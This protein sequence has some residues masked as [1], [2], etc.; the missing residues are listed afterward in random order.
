MMML[1][2]HVVYS[3][4]RKIQGNASPSSTTEIDSTQKSCK[5]RP[6]F[7]GRGAGELLKWFVKQ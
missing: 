4:E 5:Y 3:A 2:P 1:Y 6:S 7:T